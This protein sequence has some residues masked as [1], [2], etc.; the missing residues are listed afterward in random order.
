M[1]NLI[2]AVIAIGAAWTAIC[3]PARAQTP[4]AQTTD[5]FYANK[6]ID[7]LV[8]SEPGSGYDL[9]ARLI[10]KYLPSHIPGNPRIA[11]KQMMGAGGLVATNYLANIA[12][13]DGTVIAQVQNTVPFQPL[14]SDLG[15]QFKP[16]ALGYIGSANTEV[17]L[18]FSWHTSP[19][20][21]FAD[22]RSRE[23][24]M[25]AVNNSISST[26]ARALNRLAGAKIRIVTGYQG[27]SQALLALENGETEG[28]PAIFWSTL[29]VTKAQWLKERKINLL[30]QMALK[31][32]DEL[33]DVPLIMD[34]VTDAQDAAALKAILAPQ[35]GGR[36]FLAPP[37][38]PPERLAMLRRAFA[39]TMR[40]SE[41]RAEAAAHQIEL[42]ETSGEEIADLVKEVYAMSP[43]TLE[44]A[45]ELMQ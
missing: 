31:K 21:S 28:Y 32:H 7:M 26:Y 23:T 39:E 30:V 19:T 2:R 24:I 3:A 14:V 16:A 43:A 18:V 40:D 10:A 13:R 44:R 8:G 12:P 25:G 22:L 4:G 35:V 29:K 45:R 1:R 5:T 9:Y 38:L 20:R 27:A 33:P 17:A 42:H 34:L 37:D 11:V 36:P 15:V 6:T 41:L